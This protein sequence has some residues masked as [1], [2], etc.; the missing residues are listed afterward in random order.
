[1]T[2][3]RMK[4]TS[5]CSDLK[6]AH[7]IGVTCDSRAVEPGFLYVAIKGFRTDGAKFAADAVKR[8]AAAVACENDIPG[9]DVP[10]YVVDNARRFLGEQAGLIYGE[11][12]HSIK[13]WGITGTNGK[14]TASWILGEFLGN[15]GLVTTVETHT[16][17]RIFASTSTTPDSAVLQKLF[18]EMRDAGLENCV[19]E[20]SS[21]AVELDRIAGTR[22][23]GAAFTNLTEDHLDFHGTMERYFDAKCGLFT[24]LAEENPGAPVAVCVDGDY[25][26][27]LA[28]KCGML[29]LNVS[30]CGLSV[31]N[32]VS[33]PDGENIPV[34][35]REVISSQCPLVGRYNV[36]N[37]LLAAALAKAAGKTWDGILGVIP[38]LTPRWGRLE[39]V[40]TH[41]KADVFVD[42]AHTDD[43]LK[44]VLATVREFTK[45]RVW[46]VFGAGGDRDRAKRPLMGAAAAGNADVIVVTNDNPRSEKPEEIIGQIIC[47]I[48]EGTVYHVESDR[49]KAI[50]YALENAAV[51]DS[52][53]VCGKGHETTQTVGN[54]VIE[55]DDRKVC[56][57]F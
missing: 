18:A 9:L 57:Q 41:S 4:M 13:V 17:R 39:R 25:G 32:G 8:G 24:K 15:T 44:N 34:D 38:H 29:G 1:M 43:A 54:E 22:F 26:V 56:A 40:K 23:A 37:V 16:G 36:Q 51:G 3:R 2:Y 55:F 45:G 28:A 14:T 30:E 48:P 31:E 11:P 21:H 20:V 27:R 52:V 53:V 47:G 35:L 12:S 6:A 10:V 49:K 19:M 7:F 33:I 50:W 46:A 5:S 42:F